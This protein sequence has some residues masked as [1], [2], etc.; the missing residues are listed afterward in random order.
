MICG[1]FKLINISFLLGGHRP[2]SADSRTAWDNKAYNHGPDIN[3][4]ST[5]M[6]GKN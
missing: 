2:G 4:V 1:K 5:N 6:Y 3:T